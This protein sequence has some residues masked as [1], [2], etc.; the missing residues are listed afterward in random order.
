M[1]NS[2]WPYCTVSPF[3]TRISRTIPQ[4]SAVSSFIIFIISRMQSVCPASTSSPTSTNDG[5]CGDGER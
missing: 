4:T 1:A 3:S 2:G 5:D